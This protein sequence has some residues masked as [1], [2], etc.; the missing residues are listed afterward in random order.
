MATLAL[1]V[2]ATLASFGWFVVLVYFPVTWRRFIEWENALT[3]RLGMPRGVAKWMKRHE[4]GPTLKVLAAVLT[5]LCA[6]CIR[7]AS[8]LLK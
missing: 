2:A 7:E 5:M 1:S 6:L 4:T 3:I 8:Y